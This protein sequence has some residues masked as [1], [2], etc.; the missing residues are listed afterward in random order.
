MQRGPATNQPLTQENRKAAINTRD[1]DSAA[2]LGGHR[3]SAG[4][5]LFPKIF[6]AST[7]LVKALRRT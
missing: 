1:S 7:M 4:E 5:G 2:W 6:A 3:V